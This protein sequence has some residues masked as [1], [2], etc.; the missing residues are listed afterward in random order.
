MKRSDYWLSDRKQKLRELWGE[1]FSCA[2]IA[3]KLTALFHI[4]V[5]RNAVIGKAKRMKLASR[6]ST[7]TLRNGS[8]KFGAPLK[9]VP[10]RAKK[11]APKFKPE[12]FV[13]RPDPLPENLV[14]LADN[15]GCKWPFGT[16][17]P[18]HYCGRER[19]RRALPSGEV[20]TTPYCPEHYA[21][22]TVS[23]RSRSGKP[24]IIPKI[25]RVA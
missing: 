4:Q 2:Q 9:T 8:R 20:V 16:K 10:R 13:A 23:E 14:S 15:K 24:F 1:G 12:P 7:H 21:K 3:L 17:A 25:S 19:T 11:A 18:Y 6:P 22:G 5:T